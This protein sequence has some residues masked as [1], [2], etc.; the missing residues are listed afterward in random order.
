MY[1]N[2][3]AVLVL[4]FYGL[5]LHNWQHPEVLFEYHWQFE[6][7]DYNLLRII[8]DRLPG[9]RRNCGTAWFQYG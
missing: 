1:R 4:L 6:T 5:L 8:D 3:R 9:Q 2:D 7:D